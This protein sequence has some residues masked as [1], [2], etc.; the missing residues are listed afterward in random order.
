MGSYALTELLIRRRQ[1]TG[2]VEGLK[3]MKEGDLY[4]VKVRRVSVSESVDDLTLG[5]PQGL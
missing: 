5:V 4:T 3:A 1:L 2:Q